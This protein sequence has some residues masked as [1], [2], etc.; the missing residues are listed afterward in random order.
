[1]CFGERCQDLNVI[2]IEHSLGALKL[3]SQRTSNNDGYIDGLL[4]ELILSRAGHAEA[5]HND[6]QRCPKE[7]METLI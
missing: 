7:T 2:V 6:I 4:L 3:A 5:G 1:M